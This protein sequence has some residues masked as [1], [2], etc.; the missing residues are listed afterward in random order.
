M[1]FDL[2]GDLNWL[3]VIVAAIAYFAL[4]ALWYMPKPMAQAWTKSMGWD[5]STEEQQPGAAIYV[6]PLVTCLLSAITLAMLAEATGSTTV[7]EGLALGIVVAIGIAAAI[8]LVTGWFGPKKPQPM[9]FA[10][11]T[12]GYHVVGLVVTAVIV[13]AW[14]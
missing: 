4:G 7:G 10:A 6:A 3:A 8:V 9:V 2:L 1:S 14:T 5:P 12:A 13:S 11:I